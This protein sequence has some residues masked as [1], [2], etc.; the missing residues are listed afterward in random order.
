MPYS[1]HRHRFWFAQLSERAIDLSLQ[2]VLDASKLLNLLSA[3][4][5]LR[6]VSLPC[7]FHILFTAGHY[8]ER[9]FKC[10]KLRRLLLLKVTN[11][12]VHLLAQ[13]SEGCE[14]AWVSQRIEPFTLLLDLA[15]KLVLLL[16]LFL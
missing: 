3:S 15:L 12:V 9:R 6:S 16:S 8:A 7:T 2:M 10:G 5:V 11:T 13:V 1:T 14:S 4:L